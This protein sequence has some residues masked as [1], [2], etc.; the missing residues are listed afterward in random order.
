MPPPPMPPVAHDS[1]CHAVMVP[2]FF[3]AS[4]I[5]AKAEGRLP[6]VS[7]SMAR[8]RKILT[9]RPPAFFESSAEAASQR[10]AENLLPNAPP[11]WS[12]WTL[13]FFASTFNC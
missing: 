2:S 4:L 9:G 12:W 5:F 6:A 3:A 8:S 11:M 1:D 7:S 10:S 13:M